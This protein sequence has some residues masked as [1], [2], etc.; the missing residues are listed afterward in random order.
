M[1]LIKTHIIRV[2]LCAAA[3]INVV[4]YTSCGGCTDD[5]TKTN[6]L[7]RNY[8]ARADSFFYKDMADSALTLHKKALAVAHTPEERVHA[9][10][11]VAATHYYM[12]NIKAT[13]TIV[14]KCLSHIHNMKQSL[15]PEMQKCKL[16]ALVLLAEVYNETERYSD[17]VR[18]NMRATQIAKHIGDIETEV[19]CI[20]YI[21]QREELSGNYASAIDGYLE[22]LAICEKNNLDSEA[23]N[24]Y[25]HLQ[26]AY[27]KIGEEKQTQHYINLMRKST[28]NVT[29]L[30]R[31]ITAL[32]ELKLAVNSGDENSQHLN[33]DVLKYLE[34]ESDVNSFKSLNINGALTYYYVSIN[35]YE[36][37]KKYLTRLDEGPRVDSTQTFFVQMMR[38]DVAMMVNKNAEAKRILLS[39]DKELLRHRDIS[40]YERYLQLLTKCCHRIGDE[41]SAYTYN[42]TLLALRDSL[43]TESGS[44]NL[45]YRSMMQNR[46]TTVLS[47]KLR[48]VRQQNKMN[49]ITLHREIFAYVA[50]LLVF[51]AMIMTLWLYWRRSRRKKKIIEQQNEQLRCEVAM[52]KQLLELQSKELMQKSNF[53]AREHNYA[54][55]LQ[56]KNL[57]PESVLDCPCIT[58][59]FVLFQPCNGSVGGD[60]Y[61]FNR[62]GDNLF[63]CCGDAT[64]HGV[65]GAF[66]AMISYICLNDI[67][68][69][70]PD[71][72]PLALVNR[73]DKNLNHILHNNS[74]FQCTDS[75][76]LSMLCINM[77]TRRISLVLA[78]QMAFVVSEDG[79][80]TDIVGTQRSLGDTEEKFNERQFFEQEITLQ[81]TDT[82]YLTTD[83]LSS[84]IGGAKQSTFKRK[85]VRKSLVD[86]R[87]SPLS[88]QKNMLSETI[89]D[90]RGD[91]PQTDDI[92]VIGLKIDTSR[93]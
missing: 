23:F 52:Y 25:N 56:R 93:V 16:T 68:H 73:F 33:A 30:Q 39:V 79:Y 49:E 10:L 11:N 26:L 88:L 47:Q 78:R 75:V 87:T 32:A 28:E 44:H 38:A 89:R 84:Q 12:G 76:D 65:P 40:L 18:Q 2:L 92:L 17:A 3:F 4:A 71:I 69:A 29:P 34:G 36:Q 20:L 54:A 37:A 72:T 7:Y 60:F 8:T 21:A 61:W 46:D 90:W 77:N 9:Y 86:I 27:L 59:R 6:A 43:Q 82:I 51:V 50:G 1:K 81:P 48:I 57:S 58:E 64:G 85:N 70:S 35:D 66:I 55:Y 42:A 62:V 91:T 80:V 83:G 14:S 31:C 45:A 15:S 5:E 24:I 74:T 13:E 41:H 63:I 19:A 53:Y 67:V 22:A